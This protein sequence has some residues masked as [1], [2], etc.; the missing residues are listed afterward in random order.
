MNRSW[1]PSRGLRLQIVTALPDLPVF[2]PTVLQ[3][4][5]TF[6]SVELNWLIIN[7]VYS[8]GGLER[9]EVFF[10]PLP[11]Q[12]NFTAL[13]DARIRN[14]NIC[15]LRRISY[16]CS[17]WK[18]EEHGTNGRE[19]WGKIWWKEVDGGI[20]DRQFRATGVVGV[21]LCLHPI[22][23][24]F[25]SNRQMQFINQQKFIWKKNWINNSLFLL[26]FAIESVASKW[27]PLLHP[28]F[29]PISYWKCLEI[30]ILSAT[31]AIFWW[32]IFQTNFYVADRLLFD[33][34]FESDSCLIR[35]HWRAPLPPPPTHPTH[36][37]SIKL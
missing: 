32:G 7:R 19:N 10:L 8:L 20:I 21:V 13:P 3:R 29:Q 24:I 25:A 9:R 23:N 35:S 14:F 34:I 17:Q 36:I 11:Q 2:I 27:R 15:S 26:F 28:Q 6:P 18:G 33:W 16:S 12:F 5:K 31:L 4:T 37:T 1:W 30:K 22:D